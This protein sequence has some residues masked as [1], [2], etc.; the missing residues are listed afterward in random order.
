MKVDNECYWEGTDYESQKKLNAA[1][2]ILYLRLNE[3]YSTYNSME[4][5]SLHIC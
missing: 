1:G 4:L 3:T 5:L 2:S